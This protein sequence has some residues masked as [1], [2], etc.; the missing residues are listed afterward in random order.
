MSP[1]PILVVCMGVSG[2]G[3]STLARALAAALDWT[4][5][6]GDDLHGPQNRAHMAAGRPLTDAMREPWI[7]RMCGCLRFERS[8]GRN[9]VLA[10]SGL[11]R[12]H[13]QRFRKLGFRTLFLHLNAGREVIARRMAE[14]EGHYM[15]VSLLDSQF[16]DLQP[17]DREPDVVPVAADGP[18]ET[19]LEEA[20][21]QVRALLEDDTS[22]AAGA[23]Q[24][25]TRPKG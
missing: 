16:A 24:S 12:A 10:F 3:K 8:Q 7:D 22:A 17:V 13:R 18:L 19:V 5:I 11:R 6:D 4:F 9:C 2:S 23:Q 20:L 14:R 15:P 21:R 1:L 25:A